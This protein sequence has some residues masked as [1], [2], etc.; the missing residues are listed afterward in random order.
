MTYRRHTTHFCSLY[1]FCEDMKRDC[2]QCFSANDVIL[3]GLSTDI[4][5]PIESPHDV[6]VS[7]RSARDTWE[8]TEKEGL[9][10]ES[11]EQ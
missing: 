6:I 10:R 5:Y 3:K 8:F 1:P 9:P 4:V 7:S 2:F 11:W